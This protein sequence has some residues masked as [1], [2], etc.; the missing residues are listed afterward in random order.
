NAAQAMKPRTAQQTMQN[1]LRLIIR[2]VSGRDPGSPVRVGE[3]GEPHV[4]QLA[5]DTFEISA[6]LA[7]FG[8]DVNATATRGYLCPGAR[9]LYPQIRDKS[10]IGIALAPAQLMIQMGQNQV[11]DHALGLQRD[12]GTRESDAVGPAGDGDNAGG[13]PIGQEVGFNILN[14]R[15]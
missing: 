11:A 13:P 1:R 3:T 14:E 15:R 5:G 7:G 12:D 9:K 2:G 10:L 6:K 8:R 4:T